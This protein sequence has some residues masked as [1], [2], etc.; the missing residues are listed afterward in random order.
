MKRSYAAMVAS[1]RSVIS[2]ARART[3]GVEYWRN[4]ANFAESGGLVA[5]RGNTP[6]YQCFGGHR[7]TDLFQAIESYQEVENQ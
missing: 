2:S 1:A 4:M 3:Y 7:T 6:V 5:Y